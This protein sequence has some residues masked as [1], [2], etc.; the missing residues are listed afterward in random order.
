MEPAHH[1]SDRY[2]H[3]VGYLLVRETL[4]VGEEN[5]HAE[6]LRKRLQGGLELV[7]GDP[8]KSLV[9]SASTDPLL[10]APQS[11]EEVELLD[12]VELSLLRA[13]GSRAV[14][15]DESVRQDAIEPSLEVRAG[16]E[17]AVA[18]IGLQIGLL[19][20]VLRV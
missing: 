18:P 4:H 15:V 13:A 12:V 9:L 5:R 14:A 19:H 3:D 7:I 2:L 16:F 6:V 10:P 20:Q 8:R 1:C 17:A 11:T